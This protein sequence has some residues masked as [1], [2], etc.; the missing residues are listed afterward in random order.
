MRGE[1]ADPAKKKT[2]D[3]PTP[4][5]PFQQIAA[6]HFEL[7]AKKYLVVVDRF[8]GWPSIFRAKLGTAQETVRQLRTLFTTYG[9]PDVLT[10]DEGGQFTAEAT[11]VFL[12]RWGVTHRKAYP[13]NP[14]TNARAEI[15]VKSMKRLL[16]HIVDKD[17][18]Q[19]TD[20]IAQALLQ[21]RNTP[22][23]DT[24][25]SP[26]QVIFGWAIKDFIPVLPGKYKPSSHHLLSQEAREIALSRRQEKAHKLLSRGT[27]E[28]PTLAT[29]AVVL[30]QNLLGTSKGKWDRSGVVVEDRGHNQYTVQLDGTGRIATRNRQHL[31]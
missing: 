1:Y 28:L 22:D 17:S 23:R 30:L 19:E 6:D 18:D 26:A 27:R 13:Y 9:A 2:V 5:Y 8:S 4:Q 14:H 20:T 10:T 11:K 29:G 16:R 3:P 12:Q 24:G 31:R 7:A 21:Y 15:A 25:L